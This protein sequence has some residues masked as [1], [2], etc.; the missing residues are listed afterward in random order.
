MSQGQMVVRIGAFAIWVLSGVAAGQIAAWLIAAAA[1]F[2]NF[3]S[4]IATLLG[5]DT[6]L[7]AIFVVGSIAYAFVVGVAVASALGALSGRSD[8]DAPEAWA[9]VVAGVL[10]LLLVTLLAEPYVIFVV[11]AL[12]AVAG[13]IGGSSGIWQFIA[14][15]LMHAVPVALLALA[16]YLPMRALF[17]SSPHTGPQT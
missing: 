2:T 11:N 15:I 10:A 4:I 14:A 3:A 9:G 5:E 17:Y 16:A 7:G 1:A 8:P 6:A 12:P 13:L